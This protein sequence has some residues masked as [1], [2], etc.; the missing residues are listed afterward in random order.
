MHRF[1][2]SHF[3][4][5]IAAWAMLVS[6]TAGYA[7]ETSVEVA[8]GG[9]AFAGNPSITLEQQDVLITAD[10]I[11]ISYELRNKAQSA[12]A[13]L[14]TFA[15]PEL[16]ANAVA[17]AELILPSAEPANY[18]QFLPKAD[19][20]PVAFK[21]EHRAIAL[22]LDV[23]S[24]LNSAGIPLFPF[25]SGAAAKL[26][27]L[28]SAERLDLLERGILKEDGPAAVAA[29]TLKTV[30]YWR[31][32]FAPQQTITVVLSY[33]P[34]AGIAVYNPETLQ[35]LRKRTCVTPAIERAI[36][37]LPSEGGVAPVLT[38]VGFLA[39]A[40]ADLLGPARRFRMIIETSDRLT[41]VATCREGLV[42]TGPMQLEWTASDHIHEDD[43]HVLFAR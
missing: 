24:S 17:D 19:G 11:T 33:R 31:Q 3:P 43:L 35:T 29:W 26:A 15:L 14:V 2:S 30:A 41:I 18:V 13:I 12:Q 9:L 32:T 5:A 4:A 7:A 16:D 22:G 1:V 36:A 37:Q 25:G 10:A 21:I 27:D 34:I 8:A 39:S 6:A 42:R 28:G 20:Q 23:T 38:S 40:G